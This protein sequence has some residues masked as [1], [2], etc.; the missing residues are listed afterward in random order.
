M[1]EDHQSV[2][3]DGVFRSD[4]GGATWEQV[5]PM[6]SGAIG[7]K[8]YTPSDIE[9][10]SNGRIFVGTMENQDK[11]GG[12][13]V[14]YSDSGLPGSW[15]IY[16]YYNDLI[17]NEVTYN[18]P[19]RTL[20]ATSLTNPDVVY[21]QYAAG[22]TN[23][24]VYYRGRYMS[25]SA[26][27]G[28]NWSQINKPNNDWATLAWHA[29][30]LKVDPSDPNT[31]YTGGLDLYKSSNGGSNWDRISDWSLMY[32]GGGAEYVHADQHNIQFQP[33]SNST[34]VFSSDGGVFLTN[35]ANYSQPIFI[36]RNQGYNTL[37]FYSCCIRPT[38]FPQQF[39]GGLQDN[40]TL[41]YNGQAFNIGDMIDGGDGAYC[42]WD[43][44]EPNIYITSVYYN[45][46]TSWSNGNHADYFGG[47]TGTFISPADYDYKENIL[48]SNA[49]GFFGD[50]S[51]KLLKVS[52][53][54]FNVNTQLINI[55]TDIIVPFS[56]ISYSK[57][58]SEGTS[59]LFVGSQVGNLYK[60][61]NA[62]SNPETTEIGSSDFPTANI[63]CVAIGEDEDNLLVTFSNYGVSS[64]W[65]T[66]D[67][68][69][70][71]EE[72]EAN[73]PDMPIRW[74]IFHPNNSGQ[75]ILATEIGVWWTNTLNESNTYWTPSIEGMANVRVDM[76]KLR[77][78]DNKVLAASHGRGLFTANYEENPFMLALMKIEIMIVN[79]VFIPTRQL[80]I[81]IFQQAFLLRVK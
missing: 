62:Q 69:T 55:G 22:Y 1:G 57:Y 34:A 32:Y 79:F 45:D 59:T 50:N 40:G 42:F 14:L 29:F 2:P 80:A 15:I 31:L 68:G 43:Q 72:K 58:S 11:Q 78:T 28:V 9:V 36:E 52:N 60:V 54:P 10:S 39:I 63:S 81:L 53:I 56:H 20:V 5:L 41:I 35:T 65:H 17:S 37:Q 21:A 12:A 71:W 74:A 13:T 6:I 4:D 61:I 16:D 47:N 67:G 70:T 64:V 7:N 76:L 30:V 27:G 8:P 75:A 44:D 66:A 51:N 18:I 73:L 38:T 25:S 77:N 33:G 24:F 19:A 46:Y 49:V 26:D 48:Y 3:S 23:G